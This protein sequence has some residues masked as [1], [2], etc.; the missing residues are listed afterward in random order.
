MRVAILYGKLFNNFVRFFGISMKPLYKYLPVEYA[1]GLVNKGTI[2]LG[3]LSDY[4]NQ[5]HYG[6]DIGDKDEGSLTEWSR[7]N[8]ENVTN[9]ALNRIERQ[10]I[11]IPEGVKGVV[12]KDCLSAV[13]HKYSDL[14]VFSTSRAFNVQLM[15]TIS[16]D[17]HKKYDA[18]VRIHYPQEFISTVSN[19]FKETGKFEESSLCRYISRMKH[20]SKSAPHP[21]FIKEPRYQYQEEVRAVWSPRSEKKVESS[22]LEIPELSKYCELYYVDSGNSTEDGVPLISEKYFENDVVKID[23]SA[24]YKCLFKNSEIAYCAEDVIS[25]DSCEFHN[26]HWTFGGAAERTLNFMKTIYQGEGD[27]VKKIIESIFE[28]IK[29][30]QLA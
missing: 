30:P 6:E 22:I 8:C 14:Y 21:V 7:I 15:R 16:R 25:L 24:Y 23:S 13:T 29:K 1:E 2:K 19:V 11:N 3:T 27:G 26:C 18:C 5:D 12:L 17:Y 10:V 9:S 4:Q 20:H 28:S